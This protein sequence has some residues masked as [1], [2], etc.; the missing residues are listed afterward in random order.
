MIVESAQA[1]F[2]NFS[3]ICSF[4]Y[5]LSQKFVQSNY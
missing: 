5:S 2:E 4:F 1:W 3:S